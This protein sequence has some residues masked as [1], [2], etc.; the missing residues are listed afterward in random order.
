MLEILISTVTKFY[1]VKQEEIIQIIL[2]KRIL[3]I[4]PLHIEQE[5]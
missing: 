3:K 2:Y 5:Y 4:P 1:Y